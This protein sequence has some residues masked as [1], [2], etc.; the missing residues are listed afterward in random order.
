MAALIHGAHIG[1]GPQQT[2]DFC[3]AAAFN[4]LFI[5]GDATSATVSDIQHT[6][7]QYA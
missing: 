4:K 1:A 5:T 3:A 7:L 6:F 2:I